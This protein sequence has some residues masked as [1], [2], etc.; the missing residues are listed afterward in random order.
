[1][2]LLTVLVVMVAVSLRWIMLK[3][4]VPA[5]FQV[6]CLHVSQGDPSRTQYEP[7]QSAQL[8]AMPQTHDACIPC[9]QHPCRIAIS[10]HT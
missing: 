5:E 6:R 10:I 8:T 3:C 7:C 9:M 2:H 4:F 1:M